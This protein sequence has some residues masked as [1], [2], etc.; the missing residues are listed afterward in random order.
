M[1]HNPLGQSTEYC[2]QYDPSL[3]FAIARFES[4]SQLQITEDVPFSGCDYWTAYELSWLDA[5]GK[6][7]VAMATLEIDCYSPNIVES[8]SL[9]LYLNSFNQTIVCSDEELVSMIERDVG[10][11]CEAQVRVTLS[12]LQSLPVSNTLPGFCLDDLPITPTHY[13]PEPSLLRVTQKHTSQLVYSHL[14]KSNCPVTNQPDWATVFIEY[15]GPTIVPESLLAYIVSFRQ[16]QGFHE[17]CVE[18]IFMDITRHCAPD[19]L[20]VYA[21]YT[22]RGGIDI[23]PLRCSLGCETRFNDKLRIARQ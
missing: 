3:L 15:S 22:R 4:R 14:L 18:R 20:V 16:H 11:C 17:N 23:N 13:L 5:N 12:D 7:K 1:D 19:E 21:R 2:D 6:P 8:K 9:K 10:Q